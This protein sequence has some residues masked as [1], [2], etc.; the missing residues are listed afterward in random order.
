[1]PI[2]NDV[3]QPEPGIVAA[4]LTMAYLT[5]LQLHSHCDLTNQQNARAELLR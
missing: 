5:H 3:P 1:M 2:S 4:L